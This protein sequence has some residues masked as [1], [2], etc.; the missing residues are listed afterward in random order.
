MAHNLAMDG[1]TLRVRSTRKPTS[2][3]KGKKEKRKTRKS[4]ADTSP[5][6]QQNKV[7][8]RYKSERER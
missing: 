2:P 4:T 3:R 5:D 1:W 8:V 7:F 6:R